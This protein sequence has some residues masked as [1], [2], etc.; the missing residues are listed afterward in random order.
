MDLTQQRFTAILKT[1]DIFVR[2]V[3]FLFKTFDIFVR[4]VDFLFK[5]I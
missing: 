5:N 3:D 4:N 1:F 2:N